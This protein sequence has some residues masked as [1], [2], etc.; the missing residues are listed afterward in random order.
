MRVILASSEVVP[1]SKTGGLGDVAG[2]LPIA[3]SRIG[4]DVSV[5]TP[6]YTGFSK[7]HGDVVSHETG[8][9]IFDDLLVPFAG[10][11]KY[12]AV[13]RDWMNGA[14]VYFIDNAE[15]FAH[16]Y[17]Y[18]SGNF[19][20]ERFAF[21]SRAVVELAKRIGDSPDIIHCNDWQTGFIPAY[22][23]TVYA[24]DP[25]FARTATLFTIHNLAYQ[26]LFDPNL[27]LKFGFGW[28]VYQYGM[29]FHNAANAMKSGIY[30][31][32]AVSTVSPRYAQE[33]QTPGFGANLD[34]LL[35]HRAADLIGILN[36]VD[37]NE[38]NPETDKYL[39]ANYS[40]HNLGGKMAC[41]RDLLE[42][43]HL[44]VDLE[45]PVVAIISRLTS[46]KG[47][48]L[49][50][51]AVW[52]MLETGAYFILLGSGAESYEGYFQHVRDTTPAQVGVYFG[53]N[54][55]LA[56][57]IEAGADMFL[58]PSSYEPCGLNQMYSLKYGAAP[59]VRG[60]GG[61]DDTIRNFERTTG[62]G[63]GYKFYEYSGDRLVE[64]FYE[65]MMV[66][67]DRETWRRLQHNGMGQDFSWDSSAHNYL[68][69]YHQIVAAKG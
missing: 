20:V 67:Y 34:G 54:N 13:W 38:W 53:Y 39:A 7:R 58:M 46:Q 11:V 16:G 43:Y 52:P 50:T 69:A 9:M 10:G 30:F 64:K 61:L 65:A 63:N 44:P 1:Y 14:P 25:F 15:Y 29:E 56:H 42:K 55:A 41:K 17:I 35:R 37:Y 6:R 60:V 48:E 68:T 40:I 21:F 22:L 57:Q 2:A 3:L 49:I 32:T 8:E 59:I 27:L 26:G 28:D 4:C 62:Q 19:D 36:G 66:Y 31:S 45:K 23:A 47:I 18:G 24:G 33:I 5:V 51:Q 12:A